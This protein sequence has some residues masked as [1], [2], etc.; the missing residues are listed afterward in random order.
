MKI[1]WNWL[2]EIL[3]TNIDVAKASEIL[4]DIGLEIESVY[5]YESVKGGLQN[6]VVGEVIE[7][8]KHPDADKL[9]VTKVNIGNADLLN[10]VCGAPNVSTGQKVIVAQ[11][12]TTVYPVKGEPFLIKKAK[13]RG[14]ESEGMLC[15][16]NEIGLGESHEGLHILPQHAEV[17]SEVKNYFDVFL[18]TIIEIGLTANHAD[19]NSHY[20]VARELFAALKSR[21]IE[22]NI[23]I[24][25]IL[26]KTNASSA[27]ASNF[28]VEVA[29]IQGCPRYT[30]ILLSNITLKE[31]P[32]WLQNK[33]KAVGMRPINNVVDITNY[34]LHELGQPLHAFDADKIS[35]NKIVV[36]TLPENTPF[37]SLDEKERKLSVNDLMICDAEKGMCIAG[38]YGGINSGITQSTKNIFLESAYF[39]PVSIRKTEAKHGLKTDASSRFAKGT[40]PEMTVIA[41]Q[42]AVQMIL[43]LC[44]G[45]ITSDMFDIYPEKIKP[46]SVFLRFTRL[47]RLAAMKIDEKKIIEI[48][49]LLNITIVDKKTE[50]LQLEIPSYKNDV[51]REVDV[52]EEI[53][54]MYGYNN[55]PLPAF[56]KMPY[57]VTP[58]PDKE[59]L[60][61]DIIQYLSTIGFYEIFTNGISRSKYILKYLPQLETSQVKLMNS[62]NSELDC[63]RQSLLFSGLEVIA[64]NLNHKQNTLR[65][66]ELGRTYFT[67]N[68]NYNEQDV[69]AFYMTGNNAEENWNTKTAKVT[70][71]DIKHVVENLLIKMDAPYK[72]SKMRE[73]SSIDGSDILIGNEKIGFAGLIQQNILQD[74]DIKQPVYYAELKWDVLLGYAA[75]KKIQFAEIPKY[76]EVRRDL[77][78]LLAP[79]TNYEQVKN[80]ALKEGKTLLK[81]IILFDVYD[82]EKLE[83]KKSYAIGLTFRDDEKTLTDKDVDL[84]LQ[85]MMNRYETELN[86]VIRK[87]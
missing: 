58:K 64:F 67:N 54:R 12:G 77:A 51:L 11:I 68:R 16:D 9:K 1:S 23:S 62:L 34:I 46:A 15:A 8:S 28:S 60:K 55:I 57:I 21:N 84:I 72:F 38:V 66:F 65:L 13:I 31:S 79:E 37:I 25:D 82:G 61:L 50:G 32:V 85:K 63:M 33:L 47:E 14:L 35:G 26:G 49:E 2:R 7:C 5:T 83:G 70:F 10:I 22:N 76:P 41:L 45:E 71:F 78:M 69:L 39:N 24:H 48:L 6:L 17:G 19:A 27:V 87:N 4:T 59:N 56:V 18:D 81:D 42:K 29:D 30:G 52:I 74:F 80:I 73:A 44:G 75:K 86:A 53:L 43:E 40:D 36:K 3:P 20:G